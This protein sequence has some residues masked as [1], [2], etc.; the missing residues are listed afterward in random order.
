MT[1]AAKLV[2]TVQK[3]FIEYYTFFLIWRNINIFFSSQTI[4]MYRLS[5]KIPLCD[6]VDIEG[7]K[8]QA[9]KRGIF[10]SPE[11]PFGQTPFH[12][13]CEAVLI[14]KNIYLAK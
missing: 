2:S 3:I 6:Y 13:F 14:E 8:S 11:L 5:K 7:A 10:Y 12:A 4:A 1:T 9:C